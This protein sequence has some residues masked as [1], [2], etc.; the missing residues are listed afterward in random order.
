[1]KVVVVDAVVSDLRWNGK[2]FQIVGAAKLKAR[3]EML[4]EAK[5]LSE[6]Y[7]KSIPD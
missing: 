5:L 1:M 2:L 3:Y 6:T 7:S 4:V